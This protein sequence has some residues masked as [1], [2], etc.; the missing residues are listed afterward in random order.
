[1]C[2]RL[3]LHACPGWGPIV[4][5]SPAGSTCVDAAELA[6]RWSAPR[7]SYDRC[8]TCMVLRPGNCSMR[9]VPLIS[10][11]LNRCVWCRFMWRAQAAAT[12]SQRCGLGDPHARCMAT[13]GRLGGRA[14]RGL[15]LTCE[16]NRSCTNIT[17]L[18]PV[19]LQFPS[20]EGPPVCS[21]RSRTPWRRASASALFRADGSSVL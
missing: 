4:K 20:L 21:G 10:V 14:D 9:G 1:M 3:D 13:Q 11:P 7:W 19:N 5:L 18:F 2:I 17:C 12:V 15:R 8:M 6:S 16:A